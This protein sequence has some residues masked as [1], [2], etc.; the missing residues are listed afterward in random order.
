MSRAKPVSPYYLGEDAHCTLHR[1]K[2]A[3]RLVEILALERGEHASDIEGEELADFLH[4]M[5]ERLDGVL[6]Q[7]SSWP[8][9]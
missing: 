9:E 2:N 1:V 8:A 6:Q 5:A 4:L 3:M 7:A